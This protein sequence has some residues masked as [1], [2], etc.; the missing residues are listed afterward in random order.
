MSQGPG[1]EVNRPDVS[2]REGDV[3]RI[4]EGVA[5]VARSEDEEEGCEETNRRTAQE[6]AQAVDSDH[7]EKSGECVDEMTCFVQ[8]EREGTGNQVGDGIV[9][10]AIEPGIGGLKDLC[11]LEEAGIPTRDVSPVFRVADFI[12]RDA[13]FRVGGQDQEAANGEQ[14][15]GQDFP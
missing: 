5:I 11:V 3:L 14:R 8:V 1:D 6:R 15:P 4:V 12:V 7:P 10:S 13:I 2:D 9:E